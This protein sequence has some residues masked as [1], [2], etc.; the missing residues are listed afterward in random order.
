MI[1]VYLMR[2][3]LTNSGL[4]RCCPANGSYVRRSCT[5]SY[6]SPKIVV[7]VST[8]WR[9]YPILTLNLKTIM[10]FENETVT[11][12]KKW[13]NNV[14]NRWRW[15]LKSGLSRDNGLEKGTLVRVSNLMKS[16]MPNAEK[17]EEKLIMEIL[18]VCITI[19]VFK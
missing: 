8:V 2:F 14:K 12:L 15:D 7:S 19:C 4:L 10:A 17:L 18:M 13:N 6:C 16:S 5:S 1:W 3:E 11:D 9:V